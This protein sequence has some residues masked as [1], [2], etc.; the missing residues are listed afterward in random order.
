[1]CKSLKVDQKGRLKIPVTSLITPAGPAS[2]F[3]ITSEN[4]ES[5]RIYPLQVWNHVE[6]RLEHLRLHNRNTQRLL[7]RVKYFGQVVTM[8]KQDRVLIPIGLRGSLEMK[9]AVDVLAYVNYLEVWN[10]ARLMK[11]LKIPNT[12]QGEK[13]LNELSSSPRFP[14]FPLAVDRKA[15]KG[16]VHGKEWRFRVHR[17][18]H[19]KS[20]SVLPYGRV[21]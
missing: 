2:E 12:A 20:R 8:D 3:Y 18:L 10:H 19:G 6:Q 1:M 13:T 21:V 11:Y 17:R 7:A 9:G 5:V 4:G 14:R 15:K 16:H